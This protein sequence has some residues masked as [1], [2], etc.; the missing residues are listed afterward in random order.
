ML[1]GL[2]GI[3]FNFE[4]YHHSRKKTICFGA[5]WTT[6]LYFSHCDLLDLLGLNVFSIWVEVAG[7]NSSLLS[8][9][10]GMDFSLLSLD[11]SGV[12]S[13]ID[14]LLVGRPRVRPRRGDAFFNLPWT[15]PL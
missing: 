2:Y 10:S 1:M 5:P 9:K 13:G 3:F 12:D 4:I 7:N 15:F 6:Y 11:S 14:F 8:P